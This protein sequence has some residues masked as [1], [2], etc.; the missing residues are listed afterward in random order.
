MCF[1]VGKRMI[2]VPLFKVFVDV[3][4]ALKNLEEVLSSGYI[5]Q[6]PK[7]DSFE[8]QFAE[9]HGC[10]PELVVLTNSCT[11]ALDLA[12]E[13]CEVGPG[14]DVVT[15]PVTCTA[16]NTP[17]VKRN[18][19][20]VW[21]DVDHWTGLIDQ[22][23]VVRKIGVR[24]KAVVAVEWG[25]QRVEMPKLPVPLVVDRAHS[26]PMKGEKNDSYPGTVFYCYSFQA[27]K[28][29]TMSDGGAL[30]CPDLESAKKARLLRWYGLD[31][32]SGASFRCAQN[33]QPE[34]LG[35]KYQPNDVTAAIGL[36]NLPHAERIVEAHRANAL[37]YSTNLEV[38]GRLLYVPLVDEFSSHWIFTLIVEERDG[39]IRHMEE[40]GIAVS[41]VHA[42]NDK[43]DGFK[44]PSGPLPGV[45]FFDAHQVSIPVGWWVTPEQRERVAQAVHDWR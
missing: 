11:S 35:F 21:A 24:T 44:Y 9:H 5:G 8:R 33:I 4:A 1:L 16:S 26:F 25:G 19:R 39:F 45:D 7:T 37:W 13:L 36:A 12:Y 14:S 2:D 38:D 10:D 17:I 29:V 41:P 34:T 3:P 43:H 27:I 22:L 23:D 42:R 18:A 20:P 31:R 32:R 30:V 15:S 40:R 6:G 28:H